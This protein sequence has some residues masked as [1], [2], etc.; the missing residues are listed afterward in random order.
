MYNGVDAVKLEEEVIKVFTYM[1]S[2]KGFTNISLPAMQFVDG[3]KPTLTIITINFCALFILVTA[4]SS[5]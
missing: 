4:N 1:G 2:D 3:P 5:G